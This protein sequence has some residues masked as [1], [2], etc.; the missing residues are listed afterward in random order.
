MN[1]KV[2]NVTADL[3]DELSEVNGT[4][5]VHLYKD[6]PNQELAGLFAKLHNQFVVTFKEMNTLLPTKE[7][8]PHFWADPSRD[9]IKVIQLTE[10]L[11][12]KLKNT[13]FDFYIDAEYKE[14]FKKCGEILSD[15]GGSTLP[16]HMERIEIYYKQPIFILSDTM[17]IRS[18]NNT[19]NFYHANMIP[20]GEGAY[21]KVFKYKDEL[22]GKHF[23]VK[24]AKKDLS[25][26][27]IDRF[28][29]EY[30]VLK[31]YNSPY[32]VEA[33]F[34]NDAKN[35][36]VMEFV[37]RDLQ[38]YIKAN[39]NL[40]LKQ[41]QNIG[42][43]VIK[44]LEYIHSKGDFHRDLSVKNV[45]IK[46]YEKLATVKICDFNLVKEMDSTLTSHKSSKKGTLNDPA[47]TQLGFGNYSF[48][49]EIY[50]LTLLLNY[51]VT[52]KEQPLNTTDRTKDFVEK[53]THADNTKRYKTLEEIKGAFIYIT[54]DNS[55]NDGKETVSIKVD[56]R[57]IDIYKQQKE[58]LV[59]MKESLDLI[60]Y[61]PHAIHEESMINLY[62]FLSIYGN[63]DP[64][65]AYRDKDLKH[66]TNVIIENL[67]SL[68]ELVDDNRKNNTNGTFKFRSYDEE[69]DSKFDD[70]I[71]SIKRA[72]NFITERLEEY[73]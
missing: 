38:K 61:N 56:D 73:I 17:L 15:K 26:K 1:S 23:V 50:A 25:E 2:E 41:R 8:E 47:L 34:Y 40:S 11:E 66:N 49:H 42:L 48:E 62:T 7:N 14:L 71:L 21:A 32:I 31:K 68:V 63:G 67:K 36:Y 6:V 55:K 18:E 51:I 16:P 22:Y 46:D 69:K 45:L 59:S 28:K 58:H 43:Q 64:T 54:T 37:D 52:G 24:R 29:K 57:D 35:E 9:L 10:Y 27:E 60:E 20:I 19:R 65:K 4:D 33:Y 12:E 13:D 44:G 5:Y 53:G 3:L 30:N 70:S 72:Y 39:P